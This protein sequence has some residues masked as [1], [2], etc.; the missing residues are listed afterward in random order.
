MEKKQK[1]IYKHVDRFKSILLSK[2]KTMKLK[3]KKS[4]LHLYINQESHDDPL[5]HC[6]RQGYLYI[7]TC[8]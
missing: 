2:S 7:T 3:I 4:F 5:G 8:T 6:I 1:L